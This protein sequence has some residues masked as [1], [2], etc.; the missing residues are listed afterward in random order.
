LDR[1]RSRRIEIAPNWID[2]GPNRIDTAPNWIDTGPNRIDTAP[3]WIDTA[4][5]WIDAGPNRTDAGPNGGDLHGKKVAVDASGIDD[6]SWER[7]TP[8]SIARLK[9]KATG[10]SIEDMALTDIIEEAA[11]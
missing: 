3:N 5:N 2:A 4:S 9:L 6:E 11:Q 10:H 1:C 8:G 7:L